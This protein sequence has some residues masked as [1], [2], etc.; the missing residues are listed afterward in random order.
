VKELVEGLENFVRSA[1]WI[2]AVEPMIEPCVTMRISLS[3]KRFGGK[4][5]SFTNDVQCHPAQPVQNIDP[6]RL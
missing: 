4:F 2:Q 3:L 1:V 6:L 5:T